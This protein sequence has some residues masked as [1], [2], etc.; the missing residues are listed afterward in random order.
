MADGIN[1]VVVVADVRAKLVDYEDVNIPLYIQYLSDDDIQACIDTT[2]DDFNESPPIIYLQYDIL[3]FPFKRLLIDG[4][5]VEGLRLTAFKELRGEMQYN[6]G[7]I[8]SSV[9]YK[10]PQFTALRQELEQKYEQDKLRRK[11][12]LNMNNCYGGAR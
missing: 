12:H 9:Y 6:D 11:R 1:P 4:A 5:V 8:T 10:S 7:G 2:I 3:T